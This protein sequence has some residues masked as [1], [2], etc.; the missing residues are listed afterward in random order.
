MLGFAYGFKEY[1]STIPF[2]YV[3]IGEPQRFL[4][5]FTDFKMGEPVSFEIAPKSSQPY[6]RYSVRALISSIVLQ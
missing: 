3:D 5:D 6:R 4:R 2:T 1:G